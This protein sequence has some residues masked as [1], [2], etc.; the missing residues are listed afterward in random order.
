LLGHGAVAG[1]AVSGGGAPQV[2]EE[3]VQVAQVVVGLGVGR[4]AVA[5]ATLGLAGGAEEQ[6]LG[7][8]GPLLLEQLHGLLHGRRDLVLSVGHGGTRGQEGTGADDDFQRRCIIRHGGG[9]VQRRRRIPFKFEPPRTDEGSMASSP[10]GRS[11]RYFPGAGLRCGRAFLQELTSDHAVLALDRRIE[12][13]TSLF[14][15]LHSLDRRL[16]RTP[17]ATVTRAD[18]QAPGRWLLRC[19]FALRLNEGELHVARAA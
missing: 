18:L 8:G 7:V 5:E 10:R 12:P 6:F 1:P 15:E 13:G 3:G 11:V 14:L 9:A 19:R 17:L 4:A 16:A 2:A